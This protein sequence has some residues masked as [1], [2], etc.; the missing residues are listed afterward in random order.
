MG[1]H[2]G[3]LETDANGCR[4]LETAKDAI[5]TFNPD[6]IIQQ[7]FNV[8]M[9]SGEFGE[10][11]LDWIESCR[12]KQAFWFVGRPDCM[13]KFYLFEQWV[14]QGYFKQAD[15]FCTSKTMMPFFQKYGFNTHYL[16]TAIVPNAIKPISKKRSE[17]VTSFFSNTIT[18]HAASPTATVL[19]TLSDRE[20][21]LRYFLMAVCA[22]FPNYNQ[23]TI[24]NLIIGPIRQF[25]SS[26]DIDFATHQLKRDRLDNSLR[27]V[28]DPLRYAVLHQVEFIYSDHVCCSIYQNIKSAIKHTSGS[29][30]WDAL[31]QS[32][33]NVGSEAACQL[34]NASFK[35][36]VVV[37]FSPFI[38]MTAPSSAP[39]SV[40]AS[41]NISI[42][43]FREELLELLPN[44]YVLTYKTIDEL[45]NHIDGVL[46]GNPSHWDRIAAAQEHVL[47]HH[48]F[49]QRA[50]TLTEWL[51]TSFTK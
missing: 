48:T 11:L 34:D 37:S 39:L 13:S 24:I 15:F 47:S 17:L 23:Q 2:V 19:A 35:N 10:K 43:E 8:Y 27:H 25:F 7:N 40:I 44:D 45:V 38:T 32:A 5:S 20:T 1:H 28:P 26:V 29:N 22:S 12:F 49:A 3:F 6:I 33:S 41:G 9:L 30:F 36:G 50:Q 42:C 16:A 14:E 4:D 18:G 46:E 51:N 21:C 31:E